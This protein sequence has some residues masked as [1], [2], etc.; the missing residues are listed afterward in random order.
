MSF[1]WIPTIPYLHLFLPFP[2][3]SLDYKLF[4]KKIYIAF[5]FASTFEHRILAEQWEY[6]QGWGRTYELRGRTK[7]VEHTKPGGE[8]W[9]SKKQ[10]PVVIFLFFL[11]YMKPLLSERETCKLQFSMRWDSSLLKDLNSML[12]QFQSYWWKLLK[13]LDLL[14]L[15]G[16]GSAKEKYNCY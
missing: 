2:V 3:S 11:L 7:L 5:I 4:K 16:K 13:H 6:L 8:T 1:L 10:E 9:F 15:E 14:F 12:M